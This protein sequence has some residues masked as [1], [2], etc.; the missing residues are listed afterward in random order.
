MAR[1]L[2]YGVEDGKVL[3]ALLV[4]LLD[5]PPPRTTLVVL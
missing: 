4:E 3:Y 5:E 2:V 1:H